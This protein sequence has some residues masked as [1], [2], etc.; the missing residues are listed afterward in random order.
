LTNQAFRA[1]LEVIGPALQRLTVEQ[2]NISRRTDDEEYALDAVMSRMENLVDLR[3]DGDVLSELVV[4]RKT[5]TSHDRVYRGKADI[6]FANAPG[7]DPHGFVSALKSTLWKSIIASGVFSER[8][9]QLKEE[10]KRIAVER[11][12]MLYGAGLN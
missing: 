6:S 2:C 9:V 11:K 5:I 10:A 7:V 12:I 3:T 8:N 1:W 4:L